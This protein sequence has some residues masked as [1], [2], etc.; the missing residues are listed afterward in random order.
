[1]AC[2]ASWS[3]RT[4]A[5]WGGAWGLTA[6]KDPAKVERALAQLLPAEE[7][8]TFGQRVVLHGRYVCKAR[9]P[10]CDECVLMPH[11]DYFASQIE[12]A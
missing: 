12:G 3:I 11:C 9:K 1:M 6:E 5:G 8:T 7:W 2:P 4:W 10:L